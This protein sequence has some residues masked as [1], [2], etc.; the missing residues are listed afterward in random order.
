MFLLI[1]FS[2]VKNSGINTDKFDVYILSPGEYPRDVIKRYYLSPPIDGFRYR[3]F[4]TNCGDGHLTHVKSFTDLYPDIV[5]FNV[6][7]VTTSLFTKGIIGIN[8]GVD[9]IADGV[10]DHLETVSRLSLNRYNIT[11]AVIMYT[12]LYTQI[13]NKVVASHDSNTSTIT[14]IPHSLLTTNSALISEIT[15]SETA[16]TTAFIVFGEPSEFAA[17]YNSISSEHHDAVHSKI[18][19]CVGSKYSIFKSLFTPLLTNMLFLES[20]SQFSETFMNIVNF[21]QIE[22]VPTSIQIMASFFMY[23]TKYLPNE[24][25]NVAQYDTARLLSELQT[26]YTSFSSTGISKWAEVGF[27]LHYVFPPSELGDDGEIRLDSVIEV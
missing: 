1:F 15:D 16:A 4:L 9:E 2:K 24:R 6:L 20:Y 3:W 25:V 22:S 14:I 10:I 17:L 26:R 18:F 7:A 27:A 21:P 11:R 12:P 8:S 13:V 5:V 19:L 23:L